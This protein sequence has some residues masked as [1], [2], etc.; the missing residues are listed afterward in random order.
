[1]NAKIARFT[2]NNQIITASHIQK[3]STRVTM[4]ELSINNGPSSEL[5]N[6]SKYEEQEGGWFPNGWGT[7]SRPLYW[8]FD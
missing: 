5:I 1:M 6:L 8:I 4:N 7:D 3:I 2:T